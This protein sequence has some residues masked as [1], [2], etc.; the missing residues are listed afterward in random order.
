[1]SS[2]RNTQNGK[3]ESIRFAHERI[4]NSKRLAEIL[5]PK[6]PYTL[7]FTV[8]IKLEEDP[9]RFVKMEDDPFRYVPKRQ[10]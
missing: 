4:V 7:F 10:V 6:I 8:A 3:Y 5:T 2:P 9:F 1:M